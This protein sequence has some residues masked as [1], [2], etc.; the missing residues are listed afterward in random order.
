MRLHQV[1]TLSP[2]KILYR[3]VSCMCSATGNLESDCQK[4]KSFS[5]NTTDD[6]T[7]DPIYSK[8][9]EVEWHSPEVVGKWCALVYDHTIYP[10]IIQEVNETH[11]QVKCMHKVGE[12]R[13]FWP[14]REDL[15]WYPLEDVLTLIPPP[16]NVTAR[17]MAIAREMI[18]YISNRFIQ[19]LEVCNRVYEL[20]DVLVVYYYHVLDPDEEHKYRGLLC[21]VFER[22]ELTV[23]A[24]ARIQVL[25][26]EQAAAS[27]TGTQVNQDRKERVSVVLTEFERMMV[28]INLFR[29]TTSSGQQALKNK[30]PPKPSSVPVSTSSAQATTSSGQQALENKWPPKPSFCA[31]LYLICTSHH[32]LWS[33]G[34]NTSQTLIFSSHHL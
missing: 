28:M 19:M 3:D 24:K 34:Q 33:T 13:F 7:E 10:G 15:H 20:L 32:L 18:R 11:C 31:S 23:E 14:L 6:H 22:H 29:G 8:P 30:W 17:H 16:E 21:Q 2:G 9:E 27:R 4:T 12:N 1:V 26:Q 25:Q 5:F